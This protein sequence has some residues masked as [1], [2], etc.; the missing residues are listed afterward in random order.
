MR[1]TLLL[2]Y[3]AV[4]ICF[5]VFV[6][7]MASAQNSGA[8]VQEVISASA[9]TPPQGMIALVNTL[10]GMAVVLLLI[11]LVG[12]GMAAAWGNTKVAVLV[13]GGALVL[14]GGFWVIALVAEGL[15]APPTLPKLQEFSQAD[16][17]SAGSSSAD[18]PAGPVKAALNTGLTILTSITLPFIMIYGL[19]L[20]LAVA[21]GESDAASIRSYVIGASVALAASILVQ[22]FKII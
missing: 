4:A 20:S 19:W 13:A 3:L 15:G 5:A 9:T 6:P 10:R 17:G 2:V 1:H 21:A 18:G 22:V 11:V 7:S 16:L 8:D 12:S 14:F